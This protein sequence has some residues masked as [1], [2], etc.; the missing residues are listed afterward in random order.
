MIYLGI[1]KKIKIVELAGIS[2][3]PNIRPATSVVNIFGQVSGLYIT[4]IFPRGGKFRV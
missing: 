4:E 2:G 3:Y 1:Q